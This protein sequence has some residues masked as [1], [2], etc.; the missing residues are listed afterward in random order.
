MPNLLLQ[1]TD[2]RCSCGNN[3]THSYPL[4]T[5]PSGAIGGTPGPREEAKGQ[6][7][8]LLHSSRH[9]HH[10]FRCAPLGLGVGWQRLA[11]QT[12]SPSKPNLASLED[13]IFS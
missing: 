8:H 4:L 2:C 12:A 7:I 5:T 11:E 3:W 13:E 10:C 6:V 9:F 1:I